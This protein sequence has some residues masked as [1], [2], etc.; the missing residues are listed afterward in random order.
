MGLGSDNS[1]PFPWVC[2]GYYRPLTISSTSLSPFL[3]RL[4]AYYRLLRACWHT[5]SYNVPLYRAWGH[6][7]S[8]SRVSASYNRTL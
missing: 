5:S 2:G 7:R 8:H 1:G 4:A 3:A 6:V